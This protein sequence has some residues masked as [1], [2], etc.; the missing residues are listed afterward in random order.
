MVIAGL[1]VACTATKQA[2]HYPATTQLPPLAN[3]SLR[4]I[5]HY[6]EALKGSLFMEDTAEVRS[7]LRKALEYDSLHAPSLYEMAQSYIDS[8]VEGLPARRGV[9]L[10]A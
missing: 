1:G 2:T 7:E 10:C 3:D 9:A 8:P 4:A 5:F 6:T